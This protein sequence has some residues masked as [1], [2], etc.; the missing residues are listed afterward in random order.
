MAVVEKNH[1]AI[2]LRLGVIITKSTTISY[3]GIQVYPPQV[4][5]G[6][7]KILLKISKASTP[8]PI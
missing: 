7:G 6:E 3:L 1:Q 4:G 8:H 2:K 5:F